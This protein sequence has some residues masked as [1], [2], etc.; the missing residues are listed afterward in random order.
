M[1][2]SLSKAKYSGGGLYFSSI[3]A[4]PLVTSCCY[5]GLIGTELKTEEDLHHFTLCLEFKSNVAYK[6]NQEKCA[7]WIKE[8]TYKESVYNVIS[9][10]IADCALERNEFAKDK[11]KDGVVTFENKDYES[12]TAENWNAVVLYNV[13]NIAWDMARTEKEDEKQEIAKKLD[14]KYII[15][16]IKASCGDEYATQI[17][18]AWSDIKEYDRELNIIDIIK[19]KQIGK[20]IVES[21]VC[22]N[23]DEN[24]L[25]K[26]KI[27]NNKFAYIDNKTPYEGANMNIYVKDGRIEK[28]V[29]YEKDAMYDCDLDDFMNITKNKEY[30]YKYP[31]TPEGEAKAMEAIKKAKESAETREEGMFM[32]NLKPTKNG[33]KICLPQSKLVTW[34][35]SIKTIDLHNN[36]LIGERQ[37]NDLITNNANLETINLDINLTSED[38]QIK[39]LITDNKSLKDTKLKIRGDKLRQL[40]QILVENSKLEDLTIDLNKETSNLRNIDALIVSCKNL[41][42]VTYKCTNDKDVHTT[43]RDIHD[44][45]P[46]D[47]TRQIT[48]IEA[49]EVYVDCNDLD[50]IQVTI[51]ECE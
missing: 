2:F 44:Q 18:R 5:A 49:P 15:D 42:T 46:L 40:N 26:I 31:R 29:T 33:H 27:T 28:V 1:K 14:D 23:Y 7:S 24:G 13:V 25:A 32:I 11:I 41:R 3:I 6:L 48:A 47:I 50:K 39:N 51:R 9:N 20:I 10:A 34:S 38:A 21:R 37:I 45:M 4:L 12:Y 43:I 17:K 22:D 35:D 19:N 16:N 30:K 36:K 8:D